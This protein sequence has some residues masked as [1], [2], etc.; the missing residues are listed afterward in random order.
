MGKRINKRSSQARSTNQMETST[1][2]IHQSYQQKHP[3]PAEDTVSL[4]PE[5]SV[6]NLLELI[7]KQEEK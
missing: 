4:N 2:T 6:E 5:H 7:N 3:P 1:S